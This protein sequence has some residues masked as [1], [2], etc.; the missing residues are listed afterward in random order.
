MKKQITTTKNKIF[1]LL[2]VGKKIKV[3]NNKSQDNSVNY[4][5][6]VKQLPNNKEVEVTLF[7]DEAGEKLKDFDVHV[8]EYELIEKNTERINE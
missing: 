8:T 5:Y 3:G 7:F 2:E 1:N 4:I 6:L